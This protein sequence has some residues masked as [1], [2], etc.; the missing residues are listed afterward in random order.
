MQRLEH[1]YKDTH[2]YL[3]W[4]V[5][6]MPA[7]T[8]LMQIKGTLQKCN[9]APMCEPPSKLQY[10]HEYSKLVLP[11]LSKETFKGA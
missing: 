5:Q 4:C 7:L 10:V 11:T 6:L 1:G 9:E 8:N 3:L 2:V